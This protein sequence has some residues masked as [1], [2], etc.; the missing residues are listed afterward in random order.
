MSVKL[1]WGL[2]LQSVEG[3]AELQKR[4]GQV[5][6]DLAQAL[7]MESPRELYV[8][9]IHNML[10]IVTAGHAGWSSSLPGK[11]VF[12]T[13]MRNAND[14]VCNIFSIKIMLTI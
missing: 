1:F 14:T 5:L 8:Q 10:D 13:F 12:Q 3:D 4:S 9:H 11:L 6:E 2:Q 7:G